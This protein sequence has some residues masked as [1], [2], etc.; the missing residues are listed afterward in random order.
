MVGFTSKKLALGW[1]PRMIW[2]GGSMNRFSLKSMS[3]VLLLA[4]FGLMLAACGSEGPAG[5]QGSAGPTGGDGAQGP[6]G[7]AGAGGAAGED[8]EDGSDGAPGAPGAPGIPGVPGVDGDSS[9]AGVAL[10]RNNFAADLPVSTTAALT[11]FEE[12]EQVAVELIAEDGS[13]TSLGSATANAGGMASV[14]VRHDGLAAGMY[15]I[16]AVGDGGG[17]AST[18]LFVK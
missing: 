11:G 10:V 4:I 15:S 8:G 12:G 1:P 13:S 9:T 3:L 7:S 18:A 14:D 16:E 17:K 6:A 5:P 2:K